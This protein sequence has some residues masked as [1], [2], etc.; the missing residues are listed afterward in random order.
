MSKH[1]FD[2]SD[3]PELLQLLHDEMSKSNNKLD[4][5]KSFIKKHYPNGLDVG[6]KKVDN[7]KSMFHPN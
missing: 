4:C 6:L 3:Y 1:D 5:V 7:E 2:K